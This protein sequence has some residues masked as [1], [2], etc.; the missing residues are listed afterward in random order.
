MV[1]NRVPAVADLFYPGNPALLKQKLSNLIK[2]SHRSDLI[3]KALIAPHAGY[4]YS[5]PIAASAYT[6]LQNLNTEIKTVVLIGPAHRVY[7]DGLAASSA[8]FFETP[9]GGVP[10]DQEVNARLMDKFNFMRFNDDAHQPEHCL[11]VHLPFL[12]ML[13][14]DFKIVPLL[15]DESSIRQVSDV[16]EA[17]CED[18]ATFI[19]ISSDLSH[20]HDYQTARSID[21]NTTKAI[22]TYNIE[23]INGEMACGHTAICGCLEFAK[24]HNLKVHTVDLRN[25]GDTQGDKNRVVGYGAYL[26]T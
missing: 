15:F 16:L 6:H 22:E 24:K 19:V 26:F 1:M 8:G 21:K 20:Y 23:T 25:S 3:P 14:N 13:L 10:V 18:A 7:V 11:E 5:G 17:L 12:Q 4:L 2:A 9:L